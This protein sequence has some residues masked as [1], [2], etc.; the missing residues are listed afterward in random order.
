[1]QNTQEGRIKDQTN[2]ASQM[3]IQTKFHEIIALQNPLF[4]QLAD[5]RATAQTIREIVSLATATTR[6]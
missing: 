2:L 4:H 5:H 3:G 1:V 6:A